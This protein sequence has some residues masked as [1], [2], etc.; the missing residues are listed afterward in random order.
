MDGEDVACAD[1]LYYSCDAHIF[2][3]AC[4]MNSRVLNF[5]LAR[6]DPHAALIVKHTSAADIR[7]VDDFVHV[8]AMLL[9]V[10]I[11]GSVLCALVSPLS[12]SGA[13][14]GVLC[15]QPLLLLMAFG[16][17]LEIAIVAAMLASAQSRASALSLV[18][19]THVSS[20]ALVQGYFVATLV[21]LRK[22]FLILLILVSSDVI[23]L[24]AFYAEFPF[25]RYAVSS[26]SR[27]FRDGLVM[28]WKRW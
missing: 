6:L 18:S 10:S 12:N 16:G 17:M 11:C 13:E 2:N 21:R 15:L 27:A 23:L 3:A 7:R 14:Y 8:A 25:C 20:Q 28:L 19:L 22:L 4:H 24:I 9:V 5:I 26:L 1:E